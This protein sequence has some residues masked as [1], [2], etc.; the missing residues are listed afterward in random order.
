MKKRHNIKEIETIGKF[1][2]YDRVKI[3]GTNITGNIVYIYDNVQCEIEY[4]AK[5]DKEDKVIYT[6][7]INELEEE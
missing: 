4:D 5:Y 7:N 2:I 3:K 6:H 1:N